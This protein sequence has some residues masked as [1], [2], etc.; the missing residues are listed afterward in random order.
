LKLGNRHWPLGQRTGVAGILNVTPD[1]FSD[2]GQ[3]SESEAAESR[4]RQLASEGADIVDIG[5]ESTRP[6]YEKVETSEEISRV[7]PTVEALCSI[8]SFPPISI[9]TTKTEVARAALR[10]GAEI[11]NDIEGFIGRPAMAELVAEK[12]ATCVLMY[13]SRLGSRSDNVLDSI[14]IS[15]EASV[16]IAKDAGIDEDRIILDP[17]IGFTGTR[18]DD[19]AILRELQKLKEFGFPLMIGVSRKRVTSLPMNLGLADRLETTLA[20]S[21]IGAYL[22]VDFVRVHDVVE[23]VR[24]VRMA[25]LIR[26]S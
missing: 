12:E 26:K 3:F 18:E 22:G 20:T 11:V 25:D 16:Q 8:E 24:A 19:L 2:G 4:G 6:G 13:N 9:D 17:G 1:S 21:A 23:N 15:W 14:R 10:S 7:I 5:G